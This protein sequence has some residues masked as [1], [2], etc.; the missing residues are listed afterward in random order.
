MNTLLLA[1]KFVL[2]LVI[3]LLIAIVPLALFF[4]LSQRKS[5]KQS[6][7]LIG[8]SAVFSILTGLVTPALAFWVC[9]ASM[10]IG[11]TANGPGCV[12][13][14]SAFLVLGYLFT[15]I[16]LVVGLV[17]TIHLLLSQP[18]KLGY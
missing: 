4:Y 16:T 18:E 8:L 13:G 3:P 1:G 9:A 11:Q 5:M 2:L 7:G 17:F 15:A 12:T 14:A 10:G 6:A